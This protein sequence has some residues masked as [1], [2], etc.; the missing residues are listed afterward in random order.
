VDLPDTIVIAGADHF[1]WG[2]E[3][4]LFQVLRDFPL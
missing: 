3:E 1:F 2:R 4:Q